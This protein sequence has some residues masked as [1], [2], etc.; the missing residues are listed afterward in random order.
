MVYQLKKDEINVFKYFE[1][2][3]AHDLNEVFTN[4]PESSLQKP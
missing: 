4:A 2:Q 1:K 3:C